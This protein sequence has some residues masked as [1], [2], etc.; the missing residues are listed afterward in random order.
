MLPL[1][2]HIAEKAVYKLANQLAKYCKSKLWTKCEALGTRS[3][4]Y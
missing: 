2:K 3:E 1:K 4:N